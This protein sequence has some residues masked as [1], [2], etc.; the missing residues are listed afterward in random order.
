MTYLSIEP[1][2]KN[3][4]APLVTPETKKWV[5][6]RIIYNTRTA[7]FFM[8]RHRERPHRLLIRGPGESSLLVQSFRTTKLIAQGD[9][10]KLLLLRYIDLRYNYYDLLISKGDDD[11]MGNS[12][13]ARRYSEIRRAHQKP[14]KTQRSLGEMCEVCDEHEADSK[15]PKCERFVCHTHAAPSDQHPKARCQRCFQLDVGYRRDPTEVEREKRA[16]YEQINRTLH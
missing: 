8:H 15:C 2:V 14:Q 5:V 10:G 6:Q 1:A 11:T 13:R 3:S 12:K 16:R 7:P 4:F 9:W